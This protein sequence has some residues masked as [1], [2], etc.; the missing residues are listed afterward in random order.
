M[1]KN[2]AELK[3]YVERMV[4]IFGADW[5]LKDVCRRVFGSTLADEDMAFMSMYKVRVL[6][7]YTFEF[8]RKDESKYVYEIGSDMEFFYDDGVCNEVYELS[9]DAYTSQERLKYVRNIAFAFIKN[10][11][12]W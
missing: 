8:L 6:P 1:D 11:F 9:T 7:D 10:D 4:C 5:V 3:N 12:L 2:F